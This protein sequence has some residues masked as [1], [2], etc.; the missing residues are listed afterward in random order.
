MPN[1]GIA[2]LTSTMHD[3]QRIPE[4]GD[5]QAMNTTVG[6]CSKSLLQG[7]PA[8]D[9]GETEVCAFPAQERQPELG[10]L[11][12]DE[13]GTLNLVVRETTSSAQGMPDHDHRVALT[14]D[15]S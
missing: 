2:Y 10:G 9:G 12:K 7:R 6:R 8:G 4:K 14:V 15:F 13:G 3:R 11:K 5:E 1:S